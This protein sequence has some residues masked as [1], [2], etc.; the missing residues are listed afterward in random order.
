MT[1]D[2]SLNSLDG[3]IR[4][5]VQD[6]D[7]NP[8]SDIQVW[9]QSPSDKKGKSVFEAQVITD[10]EGRF[11]I[12]VPMDNPVLRDMER[13]WGKPYSTGTTSQNCAWLTGTAQENCYKSAAQ[14]ST[15]PYKNKRSSDEREDEVILT[16]RKADTALKGKVFA[17]DGK[18]P[19]KEAYISAY[20][21][22]GQRAEGYTDA[23][24]EYSLQIARADTPEG[25]I[26][27]IRAA[28]KPTGKDAYYR[29]ADVSH[30]I[31]GTETDVDLT[32]ASAGTLPPTEA[33]E[34]Q[35]ANG[36]LHTLSDGS[37]INIPGYG[38]RTQQKTVKIVIE[39]RI[40]GLPDT[41]NDRTLAY[42]YAIKLYEKES[43]KEIT[44]KF[45]KPSTIT[46][47]YKD[48]ILKALG[49]QEANLRPA[50]FSDMVQNW[51]PIN[52]FTA[53]TSGNKITFRTDH[54]SV[55]ALVEAVSEGEPGDMDGDGT[56]NLKDIISVLQV[57]TNDSASVSLKADVNGDG[58]IGLPEA[59]YIFRNLAET[60]TN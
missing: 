30:D 34:F 12:F 19:V 1:Q 59:L 43:R 46:F 32:L 57:C 44:E 26:W 56:I 14:E 36:W 24:G 5:Q 38:V 8:V 15:Q 22:D 41:V 13:G 20:S 2:I 53:D 39:P 25:N 28:Y 49:V 48:D 21:G 17:E 3:V 7:G 37:V 9:V 31:S 18:T 27:T 42:G 33:Y 58:K 45:E 4:G 54:F 10:S 6:P 23:N 11:K 16:L 60:L 40:K 52:A 35:V 47:A 50:Y 51:Q 55:Y 29:S